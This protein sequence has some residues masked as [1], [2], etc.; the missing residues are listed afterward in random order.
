[1]FLRVLRGNPT[2][3]ELA[4]L[5]IALTTLAASA[6]AEPAPEEAATSAWVEGSRASRQP[7]T[8]SAGS[9]AWRISGMPR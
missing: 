3:E 4:A 6:A 7:V 2:P 5:I 8:P 1:M 9:T